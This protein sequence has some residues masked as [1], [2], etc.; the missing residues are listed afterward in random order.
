LSEVDIEPAKGVPKKYH[1]YANLFPG[2]QLYKAFWTDKY[3]LKFRCIGCRNEIPSLTRLVMLCYRRPRTQWGSKR[4]VALCS[5]CAG[6]GGLEGR[7][8]GETAIKMMLAG[9]PPEGEPR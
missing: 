5:S 8:M 7:Q 9:K 2:L 3:G 6:D 1:R 4:M